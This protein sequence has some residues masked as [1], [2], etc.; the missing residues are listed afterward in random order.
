[1]SFPPRKAASNNLL[2][3]VLV[4]AALALAYGISSSKIEPPK[5]DAWFQ[6]HVSGKE[7]LVLVKF[8]AEW[9]GPCREMDRTLSEYQASAQPIP[10]HLVD[11]DQ[12]PELAQHFRVSG[13]P[14]LFLFKEGEVVSQQTGSMPL[15][16]L[17]AWIEQYR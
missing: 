16:Q 14:K 11:V 7:G 12:Q 10:V 6:Q 3:P 13:I 2:V 5:D 8:G 17:A 1:M 15:D 4:V 9:C